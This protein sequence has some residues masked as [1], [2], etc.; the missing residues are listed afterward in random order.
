MKG[1]LANHMFQAL[2]TFMFS[3]LFGTKLVYVTDTIDFTLTFPLFPVL[4][5]KIWAVKDMLSKLPHINDTIG[6]SPDALVRAISKYIETSDVVIDNYMVNHAY[7]NHAKVGKC[8]QLLKKFF[9][10]NCTDNE[11]AYRYLN[12]VKD[13][14]LIGHPNVQSDNITYV[15]VQ[16]RRTDYT[17]EMW[18]NHGMITPGKDYFFRAMQYYKDKFKNVVFVVATDDR[19]WCFNNIMAEG[20]YMAPENNS[21]SGDMSLLSHCNHTIGSVGS[22]TLWSSLLTGGIRCVFSV[23]HQ[24]EYIPAYV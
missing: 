16:V 5:K 15:G 20:V 19:E 8:R 18:S 4:E 1:R 13:H 3:R 22:F 14:W 23:K 6:V 2:G 24:R 21:P 9:Q 12:V 17:N 10:F 11:D 7:I